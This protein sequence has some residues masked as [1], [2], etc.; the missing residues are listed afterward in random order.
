[1]PP[2]SQPGFSGTR[3]LVSLGIGLLLGTAMAWFLFLIV[4]HTP[5]DVHDSRL[6]AFLVM[7]VICGGLA[8]VV[9]ETTR[10]LRASSSDPAYHQHWWA[11]NRVGR[12]RDGRS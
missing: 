10:Q 2:S 5:A 11:K 1:M 12:R 3:V 4:L 7:V 6:Q 8:G 9:I